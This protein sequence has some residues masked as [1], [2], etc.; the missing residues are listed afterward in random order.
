MHPYVQ[1]QPT[2]WA[3]LATP[4][5]QTGFGGRGIG[6]G[7]PIDSS[8]LKARQY[9]KKPSAAKRKRKRRDILDD[10]YGSS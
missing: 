3:V 4:T 8:N 9:I 2:Y 1:P 5:G 6:V 10:D 7:A